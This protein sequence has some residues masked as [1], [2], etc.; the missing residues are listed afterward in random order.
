VNAPNELL[1]GLPDKITFCK[2]S[3]SANDFIV[4]DNRESIFNDVAPELARRLCARRYSVGADGLILVENSNKASVRVRFFNPDGE[5]FNTCGNGGRCAARFA[6]LSVI[7]G[8]K[9]TLETNV[10]VIDA[11]V[12]GSAVKLKF[13]DPQLIRLNLPIQVDSKQMVGHFVQLGDPHFVL[14]VK[15]IRRHPI[16]PLARKIRNNE[17]FSPHGTNVHFIEPITRQ[18]FRIRSYERG[19]EDETLACGSGCVSAAVA[20]HS[21]QQSDPPVTFEPQSSI[22]LVVHF[23]AQGMYRDLYLEGDARLI[24]WGQLTREALIGFPLQP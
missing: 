4:L 22:P 8:R 6:L 23:H 12:L 14:Y 11:D 15:D 1:S 7:S 21:S 16:V 10:G 17:A 2:L 5:E 20:T 18:S 19:I 3:A 13:V 9:L 24:Y